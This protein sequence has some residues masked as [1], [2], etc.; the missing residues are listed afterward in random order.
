M[1]EVLMLYGMKNLDLLNELFEKTAKS[2]AYQKGDHIFLKNEIM[3]SVYRVQK[4]RVKL[5]V[6]SHLPN[7]KKRITVLKSKIKLLKNKRI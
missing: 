1:I 3:L 5:W 6:L 2:K 4:G 7:R